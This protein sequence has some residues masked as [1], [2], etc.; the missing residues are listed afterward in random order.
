MYCSFFGFQEKPF[1]V[2]PDHRFLYMT[3]RHREALASILYGIRER[4]GF[5]TLIGAAGTGKTTLLHAAINRLDPNTKVA[6]IFN[7]DLPFLQV[8]ALILDEFRLI[9]STK[10][11]TKLDAFR[12]LND[13]AIQQMSQGGNVVIMVDEAQNFDN[14]TIEGLRLLSNLESGN[15]KMI[16]VVLSGQ[17]ELNPK[18]DTEKMQQFV[19]RIS[20]KRYILP[21]DK[22]DI[23]IYI[24]HR[25]KIAKYEG[26][27]LFSRRALQL[28]SEYSQGIPRK[29]NV[30][31]DN[32]LLTAYA[33]GKKRI[34]AS[35]MEETINDFTHNP[36]S[37]NGHK[38]RL[39]FS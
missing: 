10:K 39:R 38:R 35:I 12:R 4:R 13:F 22:K 24:Q 15:H 1:D 14:R 20:L 34:K 29:I 21:L 31:C 26:D 17:P 30:I 37:G 27:S 19:Q 9:G 36:Y 3:G 7:S 11:L 33:M 6:F 28:I 25:L 32:A 23:Y 18:L 5:I 2:T 8:L 16:Q